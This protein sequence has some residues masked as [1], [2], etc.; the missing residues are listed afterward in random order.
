MMIVALEACEYVL[1]HFPDVQA[2]LTVDQYFAERTEIQNELWKSVP[3]MPGAAHLVKSLV[4]PHTSLESQM[5]YGEKRRPCSASR[6]A[7][8]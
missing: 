7:V 4:R 8:F 6:C 5:A 1:S 2:Q 3:L